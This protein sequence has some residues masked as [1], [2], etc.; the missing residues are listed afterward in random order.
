MTYFLHRDK[1]SSESKSAN[2]KGGC[3]FIPSLIVKLGAL[4]YC[5]HPLVQSFPLW[6]L[7]LQLCSHQFNFFL[8]VQFYFTFE[9]FSIPFKIFLKSYI[10]TY[11][12]FICSWICWVLCLKTLCKQKH[13]LFSIN[14]LLLFIQ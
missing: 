3:Q 7:L 13:I 12:N 2:H 6:F 8:P 14:L 10:T 1:L 9:I 11:Y 4:Q 5:F